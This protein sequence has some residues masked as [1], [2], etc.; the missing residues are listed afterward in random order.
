[1]ARERQ[2]TRGRTATQLFR[3]A[4]ARNRIRAIEGDAASTIKN[5]W[6]DGKVQPLP[7]FEEK[8]GGHTLPQVTVQHS[9]HLA[10]PPPYMQRRTQAQQFHVSAQSYLAR[11]RSV[12]R[13]FGAHLAAIIRQRQLGPRAG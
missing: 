7:S 5:L 1:M 13:Y 8:A 11:P 9:A 6:R 4:R 10:V 3:E 2:E 12:R